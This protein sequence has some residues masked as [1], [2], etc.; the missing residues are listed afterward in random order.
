MR[1]LELGDDSAR[2]LGT[3]VETTRLSLVVAAV[4]LTAAV[5]AAAGPIAFISLAAPQIARRLTRSAGVALAPSALVGAVA[6]V[7]SDTLAQHALPTPLPVGVVT[8]VLGG[9]YLVG[10]LIHEARRLP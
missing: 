1:Q 5:T 3:T 6:L 10:L 4:A 8:V 2:A 9:A 7:A